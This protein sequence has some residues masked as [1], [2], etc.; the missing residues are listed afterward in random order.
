[1][2]D[3]VH[4]FTYGGA[5]AEVVVQPDGTGK[6]RRVYSKDRS[7]GHAKGLLRAIIA[8]ADENDITLV[9]TAQAYGHPIQ[10]I[11]STPQLVKFYASLGFERSDDGIALSHVPMRRVP[12]A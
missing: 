1:M 11:L 6:V 9:L 10:T 2:F 12:F 4:E 8:W 7:R 3:N 5:S